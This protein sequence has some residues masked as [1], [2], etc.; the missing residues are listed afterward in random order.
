MH[1]PSW[2]TARSLAFSALKTATQEFG[3]L[4]RVASVSQ[5]LRAAISRSS[6]ARTTELEAQLA[7]AAAAAAVAAADSAAERVAVATA[8]GTAGAALT[9]AL[10]GGGTAKG[11]RTS[12]N[13]YTIKS[14]DGSCSGEDEIAKVVKFEPF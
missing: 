10:A 6:T 9:A 13:S 2:G 3:K 14:L 4:D 7:A 8:A 5:A 12:G 11:S 1:S